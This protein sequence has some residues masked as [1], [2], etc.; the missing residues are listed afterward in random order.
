MTNWISQSVCTCI[1]KGVPPV[2]WF[3]ELLAVYKRCS[4][5]SFSPELFPDLASLPI[6][7]SYSGTIK[8]LADLVIIMHDL[9]YILSEH[10]MLS[11][12]CCRYWQVCSVVPE[13]QQYCNY[14]VY[15]GLCLTCTPAICD[16]TQSV[17]ELSCSLSLSLCVLSHAHRH[18]HAR[19]HMVRAV[20]HTHTHTTTRLPFQITQLLINLFD[21][22]VH[23][24]GVCWWLHK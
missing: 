15:T 24:S 10:S 23:S 22:L 18:K 14:I 13:K 16:L 19:T 9:L 4:C 6:N 12:V 11:L 5:S 8:M 20:S 7:L 17:T 21:N 3:C 1:D 2:H